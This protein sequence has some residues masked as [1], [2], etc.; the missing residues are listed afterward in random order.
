MLIYILASHHILY[1]LFSTQSYDMDLIHTFLLLKNI[2]VFPS[3]LYNL[4][5]MKIIKLINTTICPICSMDLTFEDLNIKEC[6]H[7][8]KNISDKCI[9]RTNSN[10]VI[11]ISPYYIIHHELMICKRCS[12]NTNIKLCDDNNNHSHNNCSKILTDDAHNIICDDEFEN[13]WYNFKY[14]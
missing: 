10:T 8:T 6:A 1:I 9:I 5:I 14:L 7:N 2:M 3:E 13:E 11:C 4:I 12:K